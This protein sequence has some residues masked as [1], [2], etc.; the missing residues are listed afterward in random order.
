MAY[1]NGNE[2]LFSANVTQVVGNVDVDA[3]MSDTSE[4]PV[5]N[6]VVKE[7]IDEKTAPA[8]DDTYGTVKVHTDVDAAGITSGIVQKEGSF[9]EIVP[10]SA[11]AIDGRSNP[12][13]PIVPS[14][15]EYAVKSVGDG[16]YAKVGETGGGSEPK[17][18][19][20]IATI[21]VVDDGDGPMPQHVVFSSNEDNPFELTDF[22]VKCNAGF[23]DGNKST[24]YI[25]VNDA[26]VLSNGAIT[27]ISNSLRCF[28]VYYRVESDGF[29]RVEYTSSG[30]SANDFNPA[31]GIGGTR[32]IPSFITT[33]NPPITKIDLYTNTGDNHAWVEGSTFELWG[34]RK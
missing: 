16:Y 1:I 15:L 10:A 9:L 32:L 26:T 28:F 3:E 14:N 25:A 23:V 8:T 22:M 30:L 6:K 27:S 5:Q 7:Y 33:G 19:E 29:K 11:G 2:V 20:H 31:C 17:V 12:F 13:T 34:V 18:Y 21:T 24:L 4:N